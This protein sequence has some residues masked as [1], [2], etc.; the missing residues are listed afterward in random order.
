MQNEYKR[1]S[2][3]ILWFAQADII[4]TSGE[5]EPEKPLVDENVNMDGWT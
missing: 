3:R 5:D 2:C 1:V 4:C